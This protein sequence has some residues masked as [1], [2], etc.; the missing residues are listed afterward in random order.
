MH[1]HNVI[2]SQRLGSVLGLVAVSYWLITSF[3]HPEPPVRPTD[4]S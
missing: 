3:G 4:R 1:V 2:I